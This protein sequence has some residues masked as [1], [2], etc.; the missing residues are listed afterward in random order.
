[1]KNVLAPIAIILFNRPNHAKAL[2][3][4]LDD[5]QT[6]DLYVIVDGAREDKIGESLLIEESIAVFKDW[7]GNVKFEISQ[8]NLGCKNRISTGLNWLFEHTDRA[9]ILE[10]DLLPSPDFFR[11]CDQMLETY[12]DESSIM[13]V[14][15]TKHYPGCVPEFDYFFTKYSSGWGWATWKRAWSHYDDK[16]LSHSHRSIFF[17]ICSYLGSYRAGIYWL[18]RLRQVLSGRKSAWDYCWMI[19]CFLNKGV[20]ISPSQNMVINSG[21]GENSTH[22]SC[23]EPYTPNTYGNKISF[24]IS[25]RT[26]FTSNKLADTWVEDHLFSKSFSIRMKWLFKKGTIS[27]VLRGR[28]I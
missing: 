13:S 15:G 18:F 6:R 21:F 27:K 28:G 9:I 1:M 20:H 8:A 26:Q 14:C 7:P 12:K 24:P 25:K 23:P 5:E 11:F 2:K 17:N 22:T 3:A 4:C 19:N 16:F 10:D